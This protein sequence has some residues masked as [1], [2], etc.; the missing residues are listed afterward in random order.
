MCELARIVWVDERVCLCL[1]ARG[2]GAQWSM[3]V[4][5]RGVRQGEMDSEAKVGVVRM[6][7]LR[8]LFVSGDFRGKLAWK[9]SGISAGDILRRCATWLRFGCC[10][11]LCR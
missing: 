2:Y 11:G 10:D 1:A 7:F 6:R 8:D 3:S 4:D 9:R 5:E